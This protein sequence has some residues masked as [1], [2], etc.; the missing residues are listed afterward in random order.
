M[1]V[2]LSDWHVLSMQLH[3][4]VE[5]E[6]LVF[7]RSNNP[8]TSV[9]T[10]FA[11]PPPAVKQVSFSPMNRCMMS[12]QNSCRL[13]GMLQ[14]FSEWKVRGVPPLW[15]S[16]PARCLQRSHRGLRG[17]SDLRPRPV[18]PSE[19]FVKANSHYFAVR[20][21]RDRQM[22]FYGSNYQLTLDDQAS[23]ALI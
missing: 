14:G 5:D 15:L 12:A 20:C 9:T 7:R 13:L 19:S 4:H 8:T 21:E 17:C 1:I 3:R 18:R 2:T 22:R 10:R 16:Q 11:G 23:W 6:G